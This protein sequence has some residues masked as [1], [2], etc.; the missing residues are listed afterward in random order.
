MIWILSSKFVLLI[1]FRYFVSFVVQFQFHKAL[2]DA[3]GHTGPLHK[4]DIY[5]SK[6]AGNQMR[7]TICAWKIVG[8]YDQEILQSQTADKPMAPQGR[9]TQQLRDTR[10]TN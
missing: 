3:A 5:N 10:K 7:Y 9:A 6:E 8:G 1:Y 4:C 2:C